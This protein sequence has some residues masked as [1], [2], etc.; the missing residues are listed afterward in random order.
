MAEVRAATPDD[1]HAIATVHVASWQVA[2]RG[3]VPDDV[4][5]DL[6]VSDRARIWA[7]RLT[8]ATPRTGTVLVVDGTDVLGFASTGPARDVVDDPAAGEL[9]RIY[10][11]PSAWDRGHGRRLHDGALDRLRIDGFTHAVLWVLEANERAL[12]FYRRRGWVPTGGTKVERD[13]GSGVPLPERRLRRLV[14]R[15]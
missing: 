7:D 6:S 3:L 13:L 14:G 10:L 1:A 8:A 12:R 9:Y 2:F 11:D 4:L 15:C 5:D